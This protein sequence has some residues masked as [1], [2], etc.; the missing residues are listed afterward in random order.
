MFTED[1]SKKADGAFVYFVR[2]TLYF[3]IVKFYKVHG[4]DVINLWV[5]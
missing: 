1:E 5:I 4:V 2:K 3:I